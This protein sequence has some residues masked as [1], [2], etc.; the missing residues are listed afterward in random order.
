MSASEKGGQWQRAL[1]VL[2]GIPQ[3]DL[4]PDVIS[5]SAAISTCAADGQWQRALEVL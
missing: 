2:E 3:R 4:K 1:E 5:F